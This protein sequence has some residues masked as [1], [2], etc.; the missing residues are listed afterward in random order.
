MLQMWMAF[1]I[2]TQHL[3]VLTIPLLNNVV[4]IFTLIMF[5][6]WLILIFAQPCLLYVFSRL[7]F[8]VQL[9]C[10][11]WSSRPADPPKLN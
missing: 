8:I 3:L 6:E 2:L 7:H 9:V 5:L 1:L 4:C 11:P 10:T